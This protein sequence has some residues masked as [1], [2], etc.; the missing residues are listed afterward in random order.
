VHWASTPEFEV[1]STDYP[2][3]RTAVVAED[4]VTR[5]AEDQV[6]G[7]DWDEAILT[8]GV[9]QTFERPGGVGPYRVTSG[10]AVASLILGLLWIFGIGSALAIVLALL[11]RREI[12]QS[13]G[14]VGGNGL[15]IGGLGLGVAGL[16]GA[17]LF[18]IAVAG[19]GGTSNT[20][21]QSSL[22]RAGA[23]PVTQTATPIQ[24]LS[25]TTRPLPTPFQAQRL[26]REQRLPQP[27]TGSG[28]PQGETGEAAPQE[29]APQEQ[30]VPTEIFS[31]DGSGS[32]TTE[33]F[34]VPAPWDLFWAYDCSSYGQDAN[35]NVTVIGPGEF[36]PV[37]QFGMSGYS[38]ERY[39]T[40]GD[41]YL[42]I[43]TPC[44][45]SIRVYG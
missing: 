31:R 34:T 21:D 5:W 39:D 22:N 25:P 45:W 44:T 33:P 42:Q 2:S 12:Q 19:N 26:P 10:I 20:A 18:A 7:R 6:D 15:A 8:D 35:F 37:N 43:D 23:A 36:Q 24:S 14:T 9:T 13:R 4:D 38:S 17:V 32:T 27:Q 28:V 30:R 11:A 41:V 1:Q 3:A 16:I 40:G 29:Q